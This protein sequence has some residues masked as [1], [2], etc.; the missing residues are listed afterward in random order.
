MYTQ[1]G[2][3]IDPLR[4][5]PLGLRVPSAVLP[6]HSPPVHATSSI[7]RHVQHFVRISVFVKWIFLNSKSD[8][9]TTSNKSPDG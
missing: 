7:H 8:P 6:L 3:G 5:T 9:E 4:A 1:R 2:S